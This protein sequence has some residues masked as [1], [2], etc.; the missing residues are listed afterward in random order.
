MRIDVFFLLGMYM[1][2]TVFSLIPGF[3][4]YLL[5]EERGRSV[6]EI[7]RFVKDQEIQ[8]WGYG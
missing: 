6:C 2:Y 1:V 4:A 7:D 3:F 8:S 5:F